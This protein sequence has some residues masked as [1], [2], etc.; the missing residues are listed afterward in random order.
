M[1]L[2]YEM[3]VDWTSEEIDNKQSYLSRVI[4]LCDLGR[5]NLINTDNRDTG[6]DEL[7]I[8]YE[9]ARINTSCINGIQ[10]GKITRQTAKTIKDSFN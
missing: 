6:I 10:T 5:L 8:I 2:I 1:K 3:E 7:N 9:N 4:Q